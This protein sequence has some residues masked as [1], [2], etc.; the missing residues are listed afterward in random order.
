LAFSIARVAPAVARRI[1]LFITQM[2]GHLGLQR[3]FQYGFGQLFEQTVFP[4]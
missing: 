2:L 1:M 3:S 4:R